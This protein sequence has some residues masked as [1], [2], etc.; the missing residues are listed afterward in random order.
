[1]GDAH[2]ASVMGG[3]D[4]L[5]PYRTEAD[6]AKDIQFEMKRDQAPCKKSRISTAFPCVFLIAAI[7][8]AVIVYLLMQFAVLSDDISLS[9]LINWWIF[10]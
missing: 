8:K 4:K 3:K 10:L 7:V 6:C 9:L 2:V 5:V 1:M